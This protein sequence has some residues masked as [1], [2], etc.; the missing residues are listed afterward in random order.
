MVLQELRELQGQIKDTSV[1]VEMDN[2]RNL[3]MDSIVA[4][5]RAQ[6]EDIANRSRAEAETW[7]K[8]KVSQDQLSIARSKYINIVY[9]NTFMQISN[10]A[11]STS[12]IFTTLLFILLYFLPYFLSMKRCRALLD[13]MVKTSAQPRLRS[14]S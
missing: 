6:Y 5:V 13:S 1:V 8:Q 3:D 11:V 9:Q 14:L 12:S 7:Y 2:S 10:I 4:E